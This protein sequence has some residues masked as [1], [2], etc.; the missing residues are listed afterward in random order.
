MRIASARVSNFQ[1]KVM[2]EVAVLAPYSHDCAR[3]PI[4]DGLTAKDAIFNPNRALMLAG[5]SLVTAAAK[6]V[7]LPATSV[8]PRSAGVSGRARDRHFLGDWPSL[9]AAGRGRNTQTPAG[10]TMARNKMRGRILMLIHFPI[11]GGMNRMN[12]WAVAAPWSGQL[13]CAV[14][15]SQHWKVHKT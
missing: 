6:A 3:R 4:A 12:C 9:Q 11:C 8:L 7:P 2:I 14:R 5:T 15:T 10:T 1:N 13:R